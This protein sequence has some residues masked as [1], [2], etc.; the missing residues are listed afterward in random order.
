[1]R[2]EHKNKISMFKRQTYLLLKLESLEDKG[3]GG[4]GVLW[5]MVFLEI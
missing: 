1:M 4:G 2:V 3:S 5:K